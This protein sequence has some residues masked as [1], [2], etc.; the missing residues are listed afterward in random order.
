MMLLPEQIEK[1]KVEFLQLIRQIRIEGADINGL[2]DY[3]TNS[4]FFT[5]PASTIYHGNFEG[6]LC[7]HSLNVYKT[8]IDLANKY[9]PGRYDTNSLIV[10]GLLHDLSKT[11][12]YEK[13]TANK[14]VYLETGTKHDNLGRFDWFAEEAYKVKDSAE[15][16]IGGEHGTN[17][18]FLISRFIPMT[19]EESVAVIN[20]H[21]ITETNGLLKDITAIYNKYSL[22]SLIHIADMIAVYLI[23]NR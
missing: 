4:D 22:A 1:N 5:A 8:L 23:E 6:G 20:H 3:L 17:S 12:F 13:Y 15:R 19:Y 14:K 21:F 11:N 18:M 9:T 2:I 16:F 10:V 7:Y